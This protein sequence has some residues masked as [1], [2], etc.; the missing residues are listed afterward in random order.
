MALAGVFE[1]VRQPRLDDPERREFQRSR[2]L[3]RGALDL[4]LD[5]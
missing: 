5:E 1:R 2:Q 3:A 4:E